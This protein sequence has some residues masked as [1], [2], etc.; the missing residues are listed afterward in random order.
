MSPSPS[1]SIVERVKAASQWIDHLW[2]PTTVL[3]GQPDT[4]PW[5][6]LA[7]DGERASSMRVRR[8]SNCIAPRPPT[9]ATTSQRFAGLWV[10]LRETGAEPPYALYLVTADPAEGEGMTSAGSNIVEPVPM[11]DSVRD[12]IAAF[13]A[14][15]HVERGVR[16]A[17]TRPTT[18]NRS[19]GARLR[20]EGKSDDGPGR[21]PERFSGRWSRKKIEGESEA[22]DA[23]DEPRTTDASRPTKRP[24]RACAQDASAPRPRSKPRRHRNSISQAA[25]AQFDHRGHR[26]PRLPFAWRAEGACPCGP[27]PRV[28]GRPGDPGLL[29]LAENAWDFTD[30]TA[31]AGFGEAGGNDVK[32][33]VAQIFGDV[34]KAGRSLRHREPEPADPQVTP[35]PRGGNRG[36]GIPR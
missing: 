11:P 23:P 9:T 29:G 14:E 1:A 25:V 16:E 17:Q 2:R 8:R 26:C 24:A 7:D 4:P 5:T 30:P 31:M 10:V 12:A 33:M 3:A 21:F 35:I 6:A 32:K 28:V 36:A 15:H 27:S 19:G 18:R 13:V 34:R 22:P 20:R